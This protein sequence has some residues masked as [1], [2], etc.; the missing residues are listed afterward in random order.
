MMPSSVEGAPRRSRWPPPH[1]PGA[2]PGGATGHL[3]LFTRTA[4]PRIGCA[5]RFAG[6]LSPFLSVRSA[7]VR[8]MRVGVV[9]LPDQPWA[10]ARHRWRRAEEYGFDHAWTYDHLGWRELV[11]GPWFDAVP[12]LTAAATV[13]SKIGLGT[14]VASPNFRHPVSFA[15][16][17]TALDDISGGRFILGLGAGAGGGSLDAA[18]LGG[19]PPTPPQRSDPVAEV[20]QLLDLLLRGG[21]GTRPGGY[22]E[23][24]DARDRPGGVQQPRLPFIVAANGPR[25]IALAAAFGQGWVTTGDR[26]AGPEGWWRAV[27]GNAARLDEALEKTG[28]PAAGVPRYLSLDASGTFA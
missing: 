22:Y 19:P 6:W 10:A 4:H 1:I 15:R 12:T 8:G 18:L 16:Q 9:I 14:L 28:R 27:A 13:T 20:T 2:A 21:H 7:T 24:A 11:D 25:A 23:G 17:L 26:A 3:L 5:G